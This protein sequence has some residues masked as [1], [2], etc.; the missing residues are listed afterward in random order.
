MATTIL[1]RDS[2]TID[3]GGSAVAHVG[4]CERAHRSPI[5]EPGVFITDH[6]Y[7]RTTLAGATAEFRA[8]FTVP[9]VVRACEC[10][11]LHDEREQADVERRHAAAEDD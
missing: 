1:I 7:H 3:G 5:A 8:Q 4:Y 9:V 11:V 10:A 6:R 2:S